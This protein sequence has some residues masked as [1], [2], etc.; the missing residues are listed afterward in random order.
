MINHAE[1][2]AFDADDTLWSN[3]PHFRDTENRYIGLLAKYDAPEH[4]SAA[5]YRTETA[6]ME[7]LGYG[8]K[9]FTISM[10]ETAVQIAGER[11]TARETAQIVEWGKSLLRIP[12]LPLEGVRET[13]EKLKERNRYRLVV[14]TKG[15]LLDQESKLERSGLADCFEHTEVMSDKGEKEYARLMARLGVSPDRFVMVGNSLRSDIRPVLALGGYAVYIPFEVTWEHEKAEPFEH[16][17]LR[18]LSRF[19]ELAGLF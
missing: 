7:L 2:I 1:V 14:A 16:P 9:A 3:E 11:L 8:A 5:L 6:N 10:L 13:L 4:I 15:D 19:E 12:I 17:R 18:Q